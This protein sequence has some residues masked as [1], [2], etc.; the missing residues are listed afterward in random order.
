[1]HACYCFCARAPQKHTYHFPRFFRFGKPPSTFRKRQCNA[2]LSGLQS[3]AKTP[4]HAL[5]PQ[6]PGLEK[7]NRGKQA[8]YIYTYSSL[9]C[10]QE[11]GEPVLHAAGGAVVRVSSRASRAAKASLKATGCWAAAVQTL[12]SK[13]GAT[14]RQR[15]PAAS[16]LSSC[17]P[18]L[19]YFTL[20]WSAFSC[21]VKAYKNDCSVAWLQ[22]IL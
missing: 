22:A 19:A 3:I 5:T 2:K 13:A 11:G 20:L 8:T 7:L 15:Q 9:A 17:G 14:Q 18:L 10:M 21:V 1:M 6:P 16:P 4:C 12:S